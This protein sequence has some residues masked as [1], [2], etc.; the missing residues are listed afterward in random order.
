MWKTADF[1]C[2]ACGHKFE[3]MY[4]KPQGDLDFHI[5]LLDDP[6][7][8]CKETGAIE[9]IIG[10]PALWHGV[11]GGIGKRLSNNFKAKLDAIA[12]KH[13]K[14]NINRHW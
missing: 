7:P 6:C 2:K 12:K 11:V 1:G 9:E 4:Q 8:E 3:S 5:P 14:G 13:P 10:A